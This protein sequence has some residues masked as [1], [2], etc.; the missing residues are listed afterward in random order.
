MKKRNR[1]KDYTGVK[2]KCEHC[3]DEYW[4]VPNRR[5]KYCSM[6]CFKVAKKKEYVC[7]NCGISYLVNPSRNT[8]FCGKKCMFEWNKGKT[9]PAYVGR[10][11]TMSK[12]AGREP[13]ESKRIR[14]LARFAK[15]RRKMLERDDF[16]CQMCFEIG[17]D[18]HHIKTIR[19]RPDLAFDLDNLITLCKK[20]HDC[21]VSRKE[22]EWEDYFNKIIK[23]K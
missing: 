2:K 11:I 17:N 8:V 16:T 13:T 9:R 6:K 18:A 4:D 10:K 7:K 5:L 12:L 20:C 21:K 3:G 19:E 15:V 1:R 22:T 23:N 14:K